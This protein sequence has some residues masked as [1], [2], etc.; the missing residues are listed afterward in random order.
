MN[1]TND[2]DASHDDHNKSHNDIGICND[3]SM[4]TILRTMRTLRI[5]DDDNNGK[6]DTSHKT[7]KDDIF[8]RLIVG[9]R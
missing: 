6:T 5:N 2:M 1:D 7:N 8:S 4:M 3:D 9:S